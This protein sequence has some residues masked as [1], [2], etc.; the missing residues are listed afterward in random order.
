M[1]VGTLMSITIVELCVFHSICVRYCCEGYDLNQVG[2]VVTLPNRAW[3]SWLDHRAG[4]G[5]GQGSGQGQGE[6]AWRRDE[7]RVRGG[8]PFNPGE[9]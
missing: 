8:Q 3:P 9:P 6:A 1:R 2:I 4:G 7:V 5:R